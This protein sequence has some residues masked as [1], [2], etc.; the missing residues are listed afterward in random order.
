MK[1]RTAA[2]GVLAL[3]LVVV[4]FGAPGLFGGDDPGSNTTPTPNPNSTV[5]VPGV[6]DGVLT[7]VPDLLDTYRA[8]MTNIGFVAEV[9]STS[10][11]TQY[12]YAR[13]GSRMV[14]Q[15]NGSRVVWTNG[16]VSLAR[17]VSDGNVTYSR[18]SNRTLSTATLTRSPRFEELLSQARYERTGTTPCGDTTCVVLGA[19]GSSVAAWQNFTATVYVDGTGVIHRFDASYFRTTDN[20]TIAQEFTVTQIGN[21]SI[22][23]PDWVE[24]GLDSIE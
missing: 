22:E 3:V 10:G 16:T 4:F 7:S 1:R 5:Q 17:E 20:R 23:R 8:S 11:P 14:D 19:E 12:V 9:R 21:A 18:P 24:E 6:E 13:D 2:L 15:G